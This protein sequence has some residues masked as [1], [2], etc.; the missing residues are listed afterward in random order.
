MIVFFLVLG[1]VVF[2]ISLAYLWQKEERNNLPDDPNYVEPIDEVE[3][4]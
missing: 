3:E 4:E 2:L 1:L